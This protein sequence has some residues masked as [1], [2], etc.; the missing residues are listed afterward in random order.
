MRKVIYAAMYFL[1]ILSVYSCSNPAKEKG[2][3]VKIETE[4][5]NITIR[6][7]DETPLYRDNFLK[8]IN[9]SVYKDF[10]FHRVVKDFMIQAGTMASDST[11]ATIKPE[12]DNVYPNRFHKRGMLGAPRWDGEKNPEKESDS[13]QFYIITG[14][15]FYEESLDNIEAEREDYSPIIYTPEQREVY[16]TIGGAP[17]LDGEYTVF[18]EVIEGMDVVDKIASVKTN[19]T[20]R[21]LK[22]IKMK[23]VSE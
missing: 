15:R 6:L 17:H 14:K 18:G 13:Q 20:D 2:S 11:I 4:Y 7:F 19:S 23:I 16:K 3:I 22:D 12:I 10:L 8:L 1:L 21:P 9:D 5:G